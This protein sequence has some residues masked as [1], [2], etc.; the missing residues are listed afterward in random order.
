MDEG[1]P[2]DL[3]IIGCGARGRPL[4]ANLFEAGFSV[5]LLEAGQRSSLVRPRRSNREERARAGGTR[6]FQRLI[7]SGQLIAAGD[8]D[9]Q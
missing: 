6:R 2:H 3:V 1:P 5:L 9:A 8:N 4:A 7:Q